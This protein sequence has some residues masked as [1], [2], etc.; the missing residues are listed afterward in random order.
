MIRFGTQSGAM[1][2]I[3]CG[4]GLTWSAG[5]LHSKIGQARTSIQ[6]QGFPEDTKP[7]LKTGATEGAGGLALETN[8]VSPSRPPEIADGQSQNQQSLTTGGRM[9][10][11]A[12]PAPQAE[13]RKASESPPPRAS[14]NERS[15][16]SQVRETDQFEAESQSPARE[17]T[18]ASGWAR[19]QRRLS[20]WGRC[21]LPNVQ[22]TEIR[23]RG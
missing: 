19:Q 6:D 9:L 13:P 1:L 15:S 17:S 18:S 2:L 4:I 3:L 11:A 12:L 22:P 14:A 5:A 21:I 10:E 7:R 16:T 8:H 20:V 23:S